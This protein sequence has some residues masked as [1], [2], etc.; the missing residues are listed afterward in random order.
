MTAPECKNGAQYLDRNIE[1]HFSPRERQLE[2]PASGAA[3]AKG[4]C[5]GKRKYQRLRAM[6]NK[7]SVLSRRLVWN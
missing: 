6:D 3:A 5:Q 7:R 1:K 2:L 4:K